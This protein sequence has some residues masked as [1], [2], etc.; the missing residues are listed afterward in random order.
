[1]VSIVRHLIDTMDIAGLSGG[2]LDELL[3]MDL[4]GMKQL[5]RKMKA[6]HNKTKKHHNN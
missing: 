2:K 6:G 1:M 4:E 3:E 5:M